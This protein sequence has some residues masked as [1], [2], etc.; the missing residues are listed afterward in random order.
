[1]RRSRR[2]SILAAYLTAAALLPAA[3]ALAHGGPPSSDAAARLVAAV[4]GETPMVDDL[5]VLTDEI[6]GRPTGSAANLRSVEWALERLR[7]AGVEARKEAFE[8]P[9]LWLERSASAT[10]SG[11]GVGFSP[12]VAAMPYSTATSAEGTT[13]PL[14]DGGRG[15]EEDFER[16]GETARGAFV[17]VET[18]ELADVPGLFTEYIEAAAIEK[19]AFAAG[20]AGVVYM[21]SRPRDVLYRHNASLG[22]DNRHPM[23]VMERDD[24]SRSLRLLRGGGALEIHVVLDIQSGGPYESYNVLGEIPGSG[25]PEEFVV[26]GAH[27]DSWGI[28]TGALDNGCNVAML[29]DLARQI[30]RLGLQ[31]RRTIRFVLWNGEEQGLY[32][33]L[34]YVRSH[35]D[36]LDR[37]VMASSFDIGSGRIVG[38]FTGGRP[39][40]AAA[41]DR[42]L[43]PVRGLGPFTQ[44]DVPIVGTDNYDFMMEGI[45]NLVADQESANYGPNY[46]ARTDTFDKVD[47][48]QLRLN[49]A[50]AA[51]VVWGFAETDVDWH[52]QSRA[53]IQELIDST[54]LGEQMRTFG[55]W[56]AWAAGERGRRE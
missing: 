54:D 47:L 19:R 30:R 12:R 38:F 50:I 34:G 46:H 27:L 51:A 52:R 55:Y 11:N 1:M 44:T 22:P 29:I 16:L 20:V 53:E 24:A 2:T 32:G 31:P 13:A 25:H 40:L 35:R 17:L 49:A 23:L 14:V 41:V 26:V 7:E 39:Q 36:E 3:G 48:E 10:V 45:G 6:G 5:R 15:T 21:G 37:H 18:V 43:A 4:L 56:K 28:G 42:A 8:M 9:A 33:S